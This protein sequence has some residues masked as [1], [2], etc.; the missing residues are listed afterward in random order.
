MVELCL[1]GVT[2]GPNVNCI[3][4]HLLIFRMSLAEALAAAT[5]NSAHSIGRGATHGSIQ[6]NKVIILIEFAFSK[7]KFLSS[8]LAPT[9]LLWNFL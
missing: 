8:Q 4:E 2:I 6:E 9:H 3:F 5:I 7:L 1:F